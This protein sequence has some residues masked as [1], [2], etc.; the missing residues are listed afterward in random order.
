MLVSLSDIQEDERTVN[1][2]IFSLQNIK[3]NI[4]LIRTSKVLS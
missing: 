2:Y 3:Q 1:F 4:W